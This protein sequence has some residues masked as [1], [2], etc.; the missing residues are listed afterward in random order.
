MNS[1]ILA[2]N[3]IPLQLLKGFVPPSKTSPV[4]PV[5]VEET[6]TAYFSAAESTW[7]VSYSVE[8]H[9]ETRVTRSQF[10]RTVGHI[11]LPAGHFRAARGCHD[12]NNET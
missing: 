4:S 3:F 8:N 2:E 5:Y 7:K 1:G 6:C 12:A 10:T 11:V 9:L